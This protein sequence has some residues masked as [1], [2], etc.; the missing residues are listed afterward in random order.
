MDGI[1][2]VMSG[3]PGLRCI[4]NMIELPVEES[5]VKCLLS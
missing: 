2:I 5:L 3:I 4:N 1:I